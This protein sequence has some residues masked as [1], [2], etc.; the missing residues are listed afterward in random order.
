MVMHM[1][2]LARCHPSGPQDIIEHNL[3]LI[4]GLV[5]SLILRYQIS[6]SSAT[7]LE[8]KHGEETKAVPKIS[9]KQMLMGWTNAVLSNMAASN[10]TTDWNDG[11]RLSALVDRCQPGLI[12]NYSSLDPHNALH[13][14]ENAMSLAEK[15]LNIPRVLLP[16]DLAVPKPD[17]L[18]V[19]TY[20][21]YFCQPDS[22]GLNRL[23][24]WINQRIPKPVSNFTTDW[25][26]GCALGAL[27]DAVSAGD[28]PEYESMKPENRIEN[29][30]NAISA[31]ERLL[32]IEKSVSAEEFASPDMDQLL[33]VTYLTHFIHAIPSRSPASGITVSGPGIEGAFTGDEKN[34]VLKGRILQSIPVAVKVASPDGSKVPVKKVEG[35]NAYAYTPTLSGHYVVEVTVG[36]DHVYGSPF[37]VK[38]LHPSNA[39]G[40]LATGAGLR[41]A[42]VNQPAHFAINCESGG[43][44]DLGVKVRGPSGPVH[45]DIQVPKQNNFVVTFT[46]IEVGPHDVAVLWDS[47]DIPGSPYKCNVTDPRGCSVQGLGLG[48]T[49]MVG[50]PQQ[51]SVATENVGE[52]VLTSEGL[53]TSGI[54]VPVSVREDHPGHYVCSY[55]LKE[56]GTYLINVWWSGALITGSPFSVTGVQPPNASKCK[57]SGLPTGRIQVGK[58]YNFI[59]D[60]SD[61]GSG[62]LTA[63]Y[64]N[65]DLPVQ[66]KCDLSTHSPGAYLVSFVPHDIGVLYLELTYSGAPI[67]GAPFEFTVNDPSKCVVDSADISK[68]SFY[69]TR[70]VSFECSTVLAG[71]GVVTATASNSQ[72]TIEDMTVTCK[73]DGAFQCSYQPKGEGHYTFNVFFDK[74]LIPNMPLNIFIHAGSPADK[75][76]VTAPIPDHFGSF[77]VGQVY[78]YKVS[79][80]KAGNA[81]LTATG[82][83]ENTGSVPTL[84]M[85]GESS[86]DVQKVT[87]EAA[88]PDQYVISI[89]WG[90]EGVPGSPFLIKVEDK[91]HADRVVVEGPHYL[92]G[93]PD[94]IK[95]SINAEKAGAGELKVTCRGEK[96]GAVPVDVQQLQPKTFCASFGAK[97]PDV[98]TI[99]VLWA[100]V[101]VPGSPFMV[102]TTPPDASKCIVSGPDVPL[103][104]LKPVEMVVD[105]TSAGNGILTANAQGI[106][107]LTNG[108][109]DIKEV[110]PKKYVL[111]LLPTTP[112]TYTL[113]VKWGD[114]PVHGSPFTLNLNPAN[115]GAVTIAQPP[116]QT[117]EAGQNI[118]IIFNASK[119]G[120]G[121]LSAS[122]SGGKVGD[123]PAKVTEKPQSLWEVKFAPPQPDIYVLAIKWAENHI[124]GSPFTINLMPVDISKVKTI[125]PT[126]PKGLGGPVELMVIT[127][128]SGKGKVTGAAHGTVAGPVTVHVSETGQDTYLLTFTP[129]KPDAYSLDV[130]FGGQNV[131]G[132]PFRIKTLPSD[133]NKVVVV[134][135]KGLLELSKPVAFTCNISQAGSGMLTASCRG[136]KLGSTLVDVAEVDSDHYTV[137]FTPYS[138][139]R[140]SVKIEWSGA[141]V[142]GSPFRVNLLPIVPDKVR[143]S[144]VHVPEDVG[145]E[146]VY[147]DLDLSEAGPGVPSGWVEGDKTGRTQ[148]SVEEIEAYTSRVKFQPT[149]ADLYHFNVLFA[150]RP[151]KGSPFLVNML[152]A[153]S[154]KVDVVEK[155][156]P[157]EG[158]GPVSLVFDV[159][160][161]GKGALTSRASGEVVGPV[162][163]QV[164]QVAPWT[165]K[166]KFNPPKPDIYKVDVYWASSPIKS[167]PFTINLLPPCYPEKVECSQPVVIG[168]GKPVTMS[169]DISKAGK[170]TLTAQC[171]GKKM[172]PVSVELQAAV[173][174][175]GIYN[176][177]F[178]AKEEG[179]YK[180]RVFFDAKE[181][182]GSPFEINLPVE[183]QFVN[184]PDF[185]NPKAELVQ[186]AFSNEKATPPLVTRY[187]GDPVNVI[188]NSGETSDPLEVTAIGDDSGPVDVKVSNSGGGVF[189]IDFSPAAADRYTVSIKLN[190]QQVPHS[191]FVVL[192]QWKNDASK[193]ILIGLDE[194]PARPSIKQELKFGV[195]TTRAGEGELSATSDGP[196]E[197]GNVSQLK[198]LP[199]DRQ[200]IYH[201]TYVPTASGQHRVHLTWSGAPIPKS[202]VEFNVGELRVFPFGKPVNMDISIVAKSSDLD[203]H[204]INEENNEK[205][206]VKISKVSKDQFKFNVN[207]KDSGVHAIHILLKGNEITGSP[208]RIKVGPR[209]NPAAVKIMK[210]P[211]SASINEPMNFLVDVSEAGGGSLSLKATG[212]KG[213]NDSTLTVKSTQDH[214][215]TVTYTPQTIGDHT[216][217]VSWADEPVPCGPLVVP[218]RA[219]IGCHLMEEDAELFNKVWVFKP[220]VMVKFKISTADAGK[221]KLNITSKGPAKADVKILDNN[222]GTYTCEFTP[223]AP[224]KYSIDV[225]WNEQPIVGSP[226]V[227]IFKSNANT[228]VAGLNLES[229]SFR[230]GVPH[231]FKLHCDSIGQGVLELQCK[232]ATGSNVRVAPIPGKNSYHCEI[233][234]LTTG[235]HE[236]FVL[237]NGSHILGSPFKVN[238][239]N[240]GDASKC[241]MVSNSTEQQ[242]ESGDAVTFVISTEGAGK[243]KLVAQVENPATKEVT[244][245]TVVLNESDPTSFNLQFVPGTAAEYLLT[246][247]YDGQHITG[248]PFKLVFA[249]PQTVTLCRA[250]GEGLTVANVDKPNRFLVHTGENAGTGELS[251]AISGDENLKGPDTT[252]IDDNT[253]E[254]FYSPSKPGILSVLVL[255]GGKHIPGS[256]FNVKSY[257]PTDPL[258]FSVV[259]APTEAFAGSETRFKV[260]SKEGMHEGILGVSVQ[261]ENGEA[262]NG[263]TLSLGGLEYECVLPSLDPGKYEVFVRWNGSNIEGSPFSMKV[264]KRPMP[265]KIKV[266]GPGLNNGHVGQ[267]GN[268]TVETSEG[269]PG[270]LAVRL[271]GPR[272]AFKINMRRHPNNDRTILVRYDPTIE[273]T[274]RVDVTW[275]DVHVPGSPFTVNVEKQD[276]TSSSSVAPQW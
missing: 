37:T 85:T 76:V 158:V 9:A 77:V 61:A 91:P 215:Y 226:F 8:E 254:V 201:V 148:A 70:P 20:I 84:H 67:K 153:D 130:Q 107:S 213:E 38:Y 155:V 126:M 135:P 87:M 227:L 205:L 22:T 27:T 97:E 174:Q 260:V 74:V 273:G 203:A 246:V 197:T 264:T 54:P 121:Q 26:D 179:T 168:I 258:H 68:T 55:T 166:V 177:V 71:E 185:A 252:K 209:P 80:S 3:K 267:E 154:T 63:T 19:M 214:T 156:I 114:Q 118:G 62:D 93:S 262:I 259:K 98:Y 195:D 13:N 108:T 217:L 232:P 188:V 7:T 230:V 249:E 200:G 75:V 256:P 144:E 219:N 6:S 82:R 115:A 92:P 193:C 223:S 90:E 172:E 101:A 111:H 10:F 117:V 192:Y 133:A 46:P 39:N 140:Y 211:K 268:F 109:V 44:G 242:H 265:E 28:Y 104:I 134:Q 274:Y 261:P 138:P 160:R 181:V 31:A 176:A 220:N 184:L 47:T 43:S 136:E 23:K 78:E 175:P 94:P 253:Y 4:L 69:S 106:S 245:V 147:V 224:G 182:P 142:K 139:D 238:F 89:K 81:R 187:V 276:T 105:A 231:R 49:V 164:D 131:K 45:T 163:S 29:C 2:Y 167:S 112:D 127:K 143:V 95:L 243:G 88:V 221:G 191:P 30:Q 229:E 32:K 169:V 171:Q 48:T 1:G 86:G 34:V 123:I 206:K 83:G 50:Y 25:S 248:S 15:H 5:W 73:Q 212:P 251:V 186:Q 194:C 11:K 57:V 56:T 51:F 239:D 122:C 178:V 241:R 72:V 228:V 42:R 99:K 152:P 271:H 120:R 204:C 132:S 196:S 207:P 53:G 236:L 189:G 40:C 180:L 266:Y 129:P 240:C 183:V 96:V 270:T 119:A 17:E 52:G 210:F 14:I 64:F 272:G 124:R 103:E 247:K 190:G 233:L 234:P 151:V 125:G 170:G 102:D 250:E 199:G 244:P 225:L 269:G 33:R 263:N 58:L 216:F 150:E 159:S 35:T 222:N 218:V 79:T 141:E 145:A 110:S 24:D 66:H 165:Y 173:S 198:V 208:F 235:P 202:P 100:Y 255:W 60:A 237:F 157:S 128:D 275:S 257:Q 12:P 59:V 21:S 116:T 18:S 41:E 162:A 113:T 137:S 149:Q 16:E 161:A 36:G 146:P 65:K